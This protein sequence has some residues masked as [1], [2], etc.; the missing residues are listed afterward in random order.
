MALEGYRAGL[1]DYNIAS[2]EAAGHPQME[3]RDLCRAP[4][5]ESPA[6]AWGCGLDGAPQ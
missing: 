6:W 2:A 4:R 5:Q 3:L 1:L